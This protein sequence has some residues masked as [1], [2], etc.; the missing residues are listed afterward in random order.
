MKKLLPKSLN[1]PSGFTLVEL[2]VV[3]T[4]IA[5]LATIGVTIYSGA[6]KAAR[7][8]IRRS[9]IL[10]IAKALEANYVPGASSPYQALAGTMFVGGVIPAAPSTGGG[11]YTLTG[12]LPGSSWTYCT[13]LENASGGNSTANDGTGFDIDSTSGGFF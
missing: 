13:D 5:I 4:I 11:A 3:I 10:S 7:D 12:T 6:Q 9:D 1:N 8:A 2:M